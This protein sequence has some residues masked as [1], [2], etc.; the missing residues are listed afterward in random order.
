MRLKKFLA[1]K[2]ELSFLPC[3]RPLI[4]FGTMV[5]ECCGIGGGILSLIQEY[6]ANRKQ[7][8]VSNGK[9]SQCASISA[10]VPQGSVLGPLFFL[11]Y[12]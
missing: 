2:L 5:L 4:G 1:V 8:V 11:I 9:T 10:E 3:Q 6:L 12:I 7:R